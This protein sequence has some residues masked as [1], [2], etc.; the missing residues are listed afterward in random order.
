MREDTWVRG[1][2]LSVLFFALMIGGAP[3]MAAASDSG[4]NEFGD[5]TDA[6]NAKECK[7]A[8]GTWETGRVRGADGA[9]YHAGG[10]SGTCTKGR[11]ERCKD[12][13]ETMIEGAGVAASGGISAVIPPLAPLAP[14]IVA[15]GSAMVLY[16]VF[17]WKGNDCGS[18]DDGR[19]F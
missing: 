15:L 10:N 2:L 12:S 5:Y 8:G 17:S 3:G 11:Y 4:R 13:N 6:R 14:G 19:E 7:A 16:G 18:L 1:A 9:F